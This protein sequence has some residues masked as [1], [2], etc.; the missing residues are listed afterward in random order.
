MAPA[1]VV[2]LTELGPHV[3]LRHVGHA[4]IV[5]APVR[6]VHC[7]NRADGSCTDRDKCRYR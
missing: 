6:H 2:A 3:D 7:L 4:E 5:A 1:A